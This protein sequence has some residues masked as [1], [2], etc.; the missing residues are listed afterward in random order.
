MTTVGKLIFVCLG[1]A[2]LIAGTLALRGEAAATPPGQL[3]ES[4]LADIQP[5]PRPADPPKT[6]R[7]PSPDDSVNPASLAEPE[8]EDGSG[9]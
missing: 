9:S 7:A 3:T 4:Q 2:I 8:V 5:A 6:S 1:L